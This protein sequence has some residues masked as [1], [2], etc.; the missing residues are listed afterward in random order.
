MLGIIGAMD[1]E[2]DTLRSAMQGTEERTIGFTR[3]TLGTLWGVPV[4]LAR[5]GI[6]KV[7]AALCAQ[8]MIASLGVRALLNIGVAGALRPSLGIGDVVIAQSAV[9]HD[10]DTTPLGDPLGMVSGPNIVHFPCDE[11]LS[12]LLIRAA[13]QAGL[14]WETGAIATGD[15]FIVSGEKKRFLADA[16]GAAACDMEGGAIAQCCYEM[17]VPYA[18]VRAVSDTRDGDEREYMEKAMAACRNEEKL[19]RCFLEEFRTQ[20]RKEPVHG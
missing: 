16:F 13:E 7:H 2:V 5:C 8:G 20:R 9:Q 6:G 17:N 15:Q 11:G 4:C 3:Y 1:K 19:L 18:A 14:S 12:T 10:V